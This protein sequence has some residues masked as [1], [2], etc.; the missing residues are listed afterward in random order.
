MICLYEDY[1]QVVR[2]LLKCLRIIVS[3]KHLLE[4]HQP[5][6]DDQNKADSSLYC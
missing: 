5:G 6:T 3:D 4:A 2:H 1:L